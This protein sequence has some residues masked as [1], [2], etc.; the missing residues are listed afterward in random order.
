MAADPARV[1]SLV[2][3]LP[4]MAEWSPQV[5]RSFVR[6][7]RPIQLG[8]RLLNVNRR[9]LLVWPTQSKVVRFEP[10]QEI[11]F[12]VKDNFTVW[13][14]TLEPTATRH[15]RRAAPRG[16]GRDLGHLEPPHQAR[17]RRGAVLPGGAARGHA[18]HAGR[19]QGHRRGLSA[20]HRA[21]RTPRSQAALSTL[22]PPGRQRHPRV[23][24]SPRPSS[25][26]PC[27]GRPKGSAAEPS[28]WTRPGS[29]PPPA[30]ARGPRG[31]GA[32]VAP[33]PLRGPADAADPRDDVGTATDE[34]GSERGRHDR[35]DHGEV[36]EL[37]HGACL[38]AGGPRRSSVRRVHRV[39]APRPAALIHPVR[40]GLD[41][42]RS[43]G[44]KCRQPRRS[45][46]AVGW[47]GAAGCQDEVTRRR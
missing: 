22:S 19:H 31:S 23:L 17:P 14:F 28:P 29:R 42:S 8:T 18:H 32:P 44:R 30:C 11:A 1:W 37:L 4:R 7:G 45:A 36:R 21:A 16:A 34:A 9:G 27:P 38:L 6:T 40:P 26:P 3:D 33:A 20:R 39:R 43:E 25:G 13:S 12:R 24:R 5:V 41:H 46:G 10:H 15:P 2:S 47:C 35:E